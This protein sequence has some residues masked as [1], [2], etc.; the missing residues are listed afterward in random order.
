M[1]AGN[2]R[3]PALSSGPNNLGSVASLTVLLRV[4]AGGFEAVRQAVPL[5]RLP[6]VP[7]A[8]SE[9]YAVLNGEPGDAEL[10]A[11]LRSAG[12]VDELLLAAAERNVLGLVCLENRPGLV[13]RDLA[14]VAETVVPTSSVVVITQEYHAVLQAWLCC[15]RALHQ[16]CPGVVPCEVCGGTYLCVECEGSPRWLSEKGLGPVCGGCSGRGA[17]PAC[18]P[19]REE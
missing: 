3:G 13:L 12:A 9:V 4:L 15:F 6:V 18:Q 19:A 7:G 11:L 14:R 2:K 16:S 10:V 1:E 17:C 8:W 5:W